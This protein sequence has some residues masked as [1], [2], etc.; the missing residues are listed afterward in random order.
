MSRR[1]DRAADHGNHYY[2]VREPF[3]IEVRIGVTESNVHIGRSMALQNLYATVMTRAG[4]EIHCLVGGD[5][6]IRGGEAFEFDTRRH[7]SFEIMLHPAPPDPPLPMECLV[8]I[9]REVATCPAN[10]R[11]NV[12]DKIGETV[13]V[14]R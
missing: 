12:P 7:D 2:R 9:D 13:S 1:I 6:F 11:A 5:F 4:D 8:E 3:S 10:Y 14:P